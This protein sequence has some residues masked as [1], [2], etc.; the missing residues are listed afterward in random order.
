LEIKYPENYVICNIYTFEKKK[1]N[2]ILRVV[3]QGSD[4]VEEFIVTETNVKK[5]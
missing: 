5:K 2:W 4:Y 3:L 1:D